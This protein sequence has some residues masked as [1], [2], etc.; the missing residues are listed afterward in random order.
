MKYNG[1]TIECG[2]DGYYEIIDFVGGSVAKCSS[3]E[4]AKKV[5]NRLV[6]AGIQNGR[7]FAE[8]GPPSA[9]WRFRGFC[10]RLI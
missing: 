6:A 10:G 2:A 1:Y 9:K 4:H 3:E 5:V 8:E 7:V